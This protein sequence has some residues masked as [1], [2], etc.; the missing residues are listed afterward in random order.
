MNTREA[1][2]M[3]KDMIDTTLDYRHEDN[4]SRLITRN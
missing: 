2:Y 4:P 3:S 1:D